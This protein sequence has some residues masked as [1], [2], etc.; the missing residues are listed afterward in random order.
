M[1][2]VDTHQLKS[3]RACKEL[4]I[5]DKRDHAVELVNDE[6]TYIVDFVGVA[7]VEQFEVATH[8]RDGCVEF[9]PHIVEQLPLGAQ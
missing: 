1:I 5:V 9:V 2:S 8:D 6:H 7:G 3:S 4:D